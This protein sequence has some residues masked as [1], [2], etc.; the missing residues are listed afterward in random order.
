MTA[1]SNWQWIGKINAN[2]KTGHFHK[3]TARIYR[4]HD[5]DGRI[6]ALGYPTAGVVGDL[7]ALERLNPKQRTSVAGGVGTHPYS[8]EVIA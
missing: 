3:D 4:V 2:D 8:G 7:V 6:L 5:A 1:R